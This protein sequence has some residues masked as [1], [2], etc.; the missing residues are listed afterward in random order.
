VLT[1]D[2]L[3]GVLLV[4]ELLQEEGGRRRNRH[5]LLW[6]PRDHLRDSMQ[7]L[8]KTIHANVC[9]IIDQAASGKTLDHLLKEATA[10]KSRLESL[11]HTDEPNAARQHMAIATWLTAL[12]CY[13]LIIWVDLDGSARGAGMRTG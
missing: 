2:S 12:E 13:K 7:N 6:S 10:L 8:V 5:P 1:G 9:W 11:K 3:E 4:N